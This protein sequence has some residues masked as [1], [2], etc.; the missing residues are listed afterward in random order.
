M[1]VLFSKLLFLSWLVASTTI[2]AALMAKHEIAL[3]VPENNDPRLL[4]SLRAL[5][6]SAD[7][8]KLLA[9]HVMY[10][11]CRCSQRII[12]HLV[13]SPRPRGLSEKVILVDPTPDLVAR[14]SAKH[15]EVIAVTPKELEAR[16]HVESAPL[17]VLLDERDQLRYLGG[18]TRQKQGLDMEDLAIIEGVQHSQRLPSLPVLGCAVS[19]QLKLLINPLRLP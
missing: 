16:F 10:S 7:Q 6:G 2:A 9:V 17:F 5:R 15:F 1:K 19:D 11:A 18:Y 4:G 12:D 13:D 3:P 14:L 8:R